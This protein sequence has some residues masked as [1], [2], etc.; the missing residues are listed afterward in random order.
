MTAATVCL[1][2]L[3]A[4]GEIS[5]I[6]D[7]MINRIRCPD[8]KGTC[9]DAGKTVTCNANLWDDQS[10]CPVH[11]SDAA[12]MSVAATAVAALVGAALA[13]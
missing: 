8:G 12:S 10:Q 3:T 1:L 4:N 2:L 6:I 13:L 5:K 9:S 11:K 7:F